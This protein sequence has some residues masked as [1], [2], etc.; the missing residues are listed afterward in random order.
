MFRLTRSSEFPHCW[1][2]VSQGCSERNTV[3]PVTREVTEYPYVNWC[4]PCLSCFC[5]VPCCHCLCIRSLVPCH[6][7]AGLLCLVGLK[8]YGMGTQSLGRLIVHCSRLELHH[9]ITRTWHTAWRPE[10][11]QYETLSGIYRVCTPQPHNVIVPALQRPD[12]KTTERLIVILWPKVQT[13]YFYIN[14]LS[15]PQL[16][17]HFRKGWEYF[18]KGNTQNMGTGIRCSGSTTSRLL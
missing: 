9:L 16:K 13:W 18:Y 4:P 15:C 10:Q 12:T 2:I 6:W 11:Q 8:E 14:S 3:P 5:F 7:N 1:V 17:S